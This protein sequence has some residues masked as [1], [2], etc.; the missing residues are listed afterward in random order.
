MNHSGKRAAGSADQRAARRSLRE[1]MADRWIWPLVL[2]GLLLLGT[3][4]LYK[5]DAHFGFEGWFG[6]YGWYGLLM[7]V[8]AVLSAK[9][10]RRWLRR[11]ERFYD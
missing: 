7:C 2:A 3:D 1:L 8:G 9:A 11:D 6:F 4:W 10:L 5:R